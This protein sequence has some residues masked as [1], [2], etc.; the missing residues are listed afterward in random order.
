MKRTLIA[1]VTLVGA[2]VFAF[3]L[4]TTPVGAWFEMSDAELQAERLELVMEEHPHGDVGS[5]YGL[6]G[7]ELD[8]V[9]RRLKEEGY[10]VTNLTTFSGRSGA[11]YALTYEKEQDK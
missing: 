8:M 11:S 10:E 3:W 6:S 9:V 7:S 1:I 5:M 2:A 4:K